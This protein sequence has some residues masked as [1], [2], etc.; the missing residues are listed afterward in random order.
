MHAT[1]PAAAQK[2]GR[3][4]EQAA[5]DVAPETLETVP[6]AQSTHASADAPAPASHEP[7]A[8]GEHAALPAAAHVPLTQGAQTLALDAH[9]AVEAVAAGQGSHAAAA[10]RGP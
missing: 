6:A 8:Q 2:P 3:H 5:A 7:A 9:V 10:A 4:E 1:E